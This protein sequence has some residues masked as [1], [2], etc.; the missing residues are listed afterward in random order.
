MI[1]RETW[2]GLVVL[3]RHLVFGPRRNLGQTV[4]SLRHDAGICRVVRP[5]RRLMGKLTQPHPRKHPQMVVKVVER[6][7]GLKKVCSK[8]A[9]H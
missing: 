2:A 3:G 8:T 9:E 5:G 4:S 6:V 7:G 1:R